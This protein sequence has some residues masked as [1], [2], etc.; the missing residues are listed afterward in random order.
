M[1]EAERV[2]AGD[3]APVRRDEPPR[4]SCRGC[5]RDLL[6]E[7]RP[8]TDFERV[9]RARHPQPRPGAHERKQRGI[10]LEDRV[11]RLRVGVEVEQPAHTPD[12]MHEPVE[13]R[14]VGAQPECAAGSGGAAR[15]EQQG[16]APRLGARR[17]GRHGQPAPGDE[18]QGR[19]GPQ[20]RLPFR[21]RR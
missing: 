4:Q 3:G 16:V 11:D 14:E 20:R 12:H 1:R 7:H 18:Q 10:A 8:D 15:H 21:A 2:E 9:D 5:D 6:A 13:G 17:S 19:D